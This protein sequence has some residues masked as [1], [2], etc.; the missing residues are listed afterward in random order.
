[1]AEHG[2]VGCRPT[3]PVWYTCGRRGAYFD[4]RGAPRK[5]T[6]NRESTVGKTAAQTGQRDVNEA[7]FQ[8]ATDAAEMVRRKQVSSRELTEALLARIDSVNPAVNAVVELRS[9]EAVQEAAAADDAIGGGVPGPLHGLPMTVKDSFNVAGLHTTWGNPAFKEYVADADATLVRRLRQ[10]GAIIVGKTNV[11]FMLADFGQTVN[12][13]YGVTSNP[14]DTTRTPGGSSGGGA[15][16]VSAGMTFLEYGSDLVGSIR[17]P[18]SFCGVYGLKPSVGIVPLTGF[19]PPGPPQDQS[20][21]TYMSAIGP[22]ARSARDLR[23]ALEVTAGPEAPAANA[24]SWA[25]SRPRHARLEDFRVGVVLD[26][27]RAPVSSEVAALLSNAVDALTRAGATVVEGWPE[28]IDPAHESESFGF[29]VGLFFAF[30][31]PGEDFAQLSKVIEQENRRMSARASWGRYFNEI[32]VFFCPANFTPAFPHDG[33]PF[34]ERTIT[35]PEGE[36][37]YTNQTF[38]ISHASLPGLP[39]VVAPIG[40]TAAGLPVGA[41][42]IGPL[43]EDDTALTFAELLAEVIGGYVPPPI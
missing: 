27:E 18:A 42:I 10:A 25:L 23:A 24:Y 19:Q 4:N 3:E 12:E 43:Y 34:D 32:D 7:L 11:H 41:Q 29:H 16:A 30:Q 13:L 14:W 5:A 40:R 35:T 28:G 31:Q 22:L 39:A 6:A 1:V 17:I 26:H 37:P 20:E 36:R 15:A 38:W 33:R 21:M 9:E 2:A 8:S